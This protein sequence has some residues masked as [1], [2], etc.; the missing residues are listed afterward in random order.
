MFTCHNLE[1]VPR[2]A[3]ILLELD[4]LD[5]LD[6]IPGKGHCFLEC[7]LVSTEGNFLDLFFS[8]SHSRCLRNPTL[9]ITIGEERRDWP[10]QRLCRVSGLIDFDRRDYSCCSAI[11]RNGGS[12]LE[13]AGAGNWWLILCSCVSGSVDDADCVYGSGC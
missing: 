11:L 2:F 1:F 13:L 7:C 4:F 9:F 8:S 3:Q 12:K 6:E 5:F 10:S